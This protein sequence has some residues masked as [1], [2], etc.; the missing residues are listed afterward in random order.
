[1]LYYSRLERLARDKHPRF[2]DQFVRYGENALLL[3]Q[4]QELY[5]QH[6]ILNI[7]HKWAQHAKVLHYDKPE[8]LVRDKQSSFWGPFVSYEENEA[9]QVWSQET[10]SQFIIFNVTYKWAQQAR[11]L[12]YKRPERLCRNKHSSFLGPFVCYEENELL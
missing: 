8:R 7:T 1:V 3:I 6:I 9:L 4:S 10:Y 12:N 2:S 11:A 5:S